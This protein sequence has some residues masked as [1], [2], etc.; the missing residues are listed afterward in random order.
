MTT[1]GVTAAGFV[2][3]PIE[4]IIAELEAAHKTAYGQ[5]FDVS[6]QSPAGQQIG[7]MALHLRECWEVMQALYSAWDPD[8]NEGAIQTQIA[9]LSGTPR[10]GATHSTVTA[11]VNLDAGITLAAGAVASVDGAPDRRFVTIE[12]ATNPGGAPDDIAV[13]MEAED[14]GPVVA[15]AGTLTE[16]E[17]PTSGWNSIT[18]AADATLGEDEETDEDLRVR[19]EIELRRAGAAAVDAIRADVSAV[20]DVINVTVFENTTDALDEDGVPAHAIEVVVLGGDD[21]E[22][23]QAIWDSRAGGIKAHGGDSGTATDVDG[24]EHTIKFSRPTE[25]PI[26]VNVEVTIDDSYPADGDTQIKEALAAWSQDL[27]VGA[28]V[29]W[30]ALFAIVFGISGVVDLTTLEIHTSDPPAGHTNNIE[31]GSRELATIDTADVDVV[32]T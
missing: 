20:E 19:R 14:T 22:I 9:A 32:S 26:H 17:T 1:Y 25:V 2:D 6:A 7:I 31:I 13:E 27:E 5:E 16:I 21:D 11:T 29:V 24:E 23:A 30:S 3:K 12:D 28:D 8:A 15:S 10:R 4:V 18:N